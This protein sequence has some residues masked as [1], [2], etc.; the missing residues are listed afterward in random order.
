MWRDI[1]KAP[2]WNIH[3]K[4]NI[5]PDMRISASTTDWDEKEW[6]QYYKSKYWPNEKPQGLWYALGS[7]W[8]DWLE[9]E[10]PLASNKYNYVYE[11]HLTG[12]ILKLKTKQDHIDFYNK[13]A[14]DAV[15][16]RYT[17]NR[18]KINWK[19]VASE[20]DGIE[21]MGKDF[22]YDSLDDKSLEWLSGWDV[23]G[24]VIWNLSAFRQGKLLFSRDDKLWETATAEEY[25][26]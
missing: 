10:M 14:E 4:V 13:Y 26:W 9:G 8:I 5:T 2:I 12:N 15:G 11:I 20:Y 17:Y 1:L 24:G 22:H 21:V 7:D 18:K 25:Y 3:Q 16:T 19:R 6:V 23:N